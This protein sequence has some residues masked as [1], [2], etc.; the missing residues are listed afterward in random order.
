TVI[1]VNTTGAAPAAV[2]Q[3]AV[4]AD[5]GRLS[6]RLLRRAWRIGRVLMKAGLAEMRK[7]AAA[8]GDE[9][10]RERARRLRAAMLELGPPFATL[11]TGERVVVKVQRPTAEADILEDLGLLELFARKAAGRPAFRE[12]VDLPAIIEHLSSSLRRE[13]DFR[14]EAGNL[15]RMKEIIAPFS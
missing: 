9:A 2:I 13:L 1:I 14:G 6:G 5:D 3:P 11:E 12:L 4:T 10:L 15:V 7:D 8:T